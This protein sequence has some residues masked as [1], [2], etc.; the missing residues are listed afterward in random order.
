[1]DNW[2]HETPKPSK[3]GFEISAIDKDYCLYAEQKY[4]LLK[5]RKK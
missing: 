3:R 5:P 1:M 4:E 2:R